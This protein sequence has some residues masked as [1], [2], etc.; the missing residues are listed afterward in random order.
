MG[1]LLSLLYPLNLNQNNLIFSSKY[2]RFLSNVIQKISYQYLMKEYTILS[3]QKRKA[4]SK[5]L[6]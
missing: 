6:F 4:V 2:I 3:T 5:P 1:S